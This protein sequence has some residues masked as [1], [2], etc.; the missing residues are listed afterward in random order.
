M[1]YIASSE[2]A[3]DVKAYINLT[4]GVTRLLSHP[5]VYTATQ[6]TLAAWPLNFVKLGFLEIPCET[7][8]H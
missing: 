4:S 5:Y 6:V 2:A 8:H 7:K 3:S 1:N